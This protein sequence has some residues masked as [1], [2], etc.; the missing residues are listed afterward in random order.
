MFMDY[1]K[2]SEEQKKNLLDG[3]KLIKKNDFNNCPPKEL[4]KSKMCFWCLDC[5]IQALEKDIENIEKSKSKSKKKKK[6]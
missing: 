3:L 4:R 5:W 1:N 2:L 6:K